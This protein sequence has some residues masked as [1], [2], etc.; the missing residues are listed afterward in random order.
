MFLDLLVGELFFGID[1]DKG[2]WLVGLWTN[3]LMFGS[4]EV[5]PC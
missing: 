4:E 1:I 5:I 2:F 3:G